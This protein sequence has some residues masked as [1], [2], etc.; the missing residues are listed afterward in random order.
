LLD[1][2]TIAGGLIFLV[3]MGAIMIRPYRIS[4]AVL[5]AG[6]AALM[7]MGGYVRPVEA[8]SIVLNNWNAYGFFLGMMGISA[9]ADQAG[10]FEMLAYHAGQWARG[11]GLRLYLAVFAAGVVITAFLSN[12]ATALILTPVV[13]SLVTRLR[14][15]VMPFMFACT[16]I[17][18]TASFIFPVSNPINILVLDAFGSGL[19]AFLSHLFLPSLFCIGLN[20][21]LFAWLFRHDLQI[22][23]NP[24]DLPKVGLFH[25]HF[26]FFTL[27]TLALI[28]FAYVAASV[29]Q[30]P[31]SIVSLAGSVLL[32][33]G[34][35]WYQCIE[36]HKLVRDISWSLFVFITG[37][38]IEDRNACSLR[39]RPTR[40]AG[41]N[42]TFN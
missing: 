13:F 38:L 23:Y 6:G 9:L 8:V 36:R 5:A 18:D 3:T 34:A 10:I 12:D 16:F 33:A 37:M 15:P 2:H 31:L 1:F 24:T 35:L 40:W 42:S 27:T 19:P 17:A 4:E 32:L 41:A 26:Y 39:S 14:L 22:H 25:R 28:A 29:V 30:F 21:A 11:S 7:L 20:I